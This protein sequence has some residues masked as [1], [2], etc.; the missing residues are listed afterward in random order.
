[1]NEHKTIRWWGILSALA[2]GNLLLWCA[3]ATTVDTTVPYVHWHL[4]LSGVFTA[5]CA[6]RSFLPRIGL[7]RLCLVD[8]AAS[9]MVAG[10]SAA[11]IAEVCFAC[12]N[13]LVLHEIGGLASLPWVQ[14]LAAP[15]V[16]IL[17]IAQIFCWSSVLTLNHLGHAIEESLWA[18][19]FAVMGVCLALCA[20]ELDGTWRAI[21]IAG[22]V[23][24]A[25]YVTFMVTVDVPM[26]V[27]RWQRGTA[28]GE[29]RLGLREGWSDA[30]HRRVVTRDWATW[31]PEVAWL[32]GYFTLAVWVSL[33]MVC[34]PRA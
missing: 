25:G 30:L 20:P 31:K 18:A 5:V 26:Y 1:M 33:A 34:L 11:T 28:A 3:V 21:G 27:R 4:A 24:C 23:S 29:R 7:E 22:A 9:S 14:S 17:T 15:M 32:T 19:T 16:L 8:T 12:Q 6:F 2:T 13:A 10:R